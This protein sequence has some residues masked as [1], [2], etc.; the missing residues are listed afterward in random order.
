[1]PPSAATTASDGETRYVQLSPSWITVKTAPGV[2]TPRGKIRISPVRLFVLPL[3]GL[4]FGRALYKTMVPRSDLPI[5]ISIQMY[6]DFAYL[7]QPGDVI[8]VIHP[9]LAVIPP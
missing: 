1:M 4:V 9:E 8:T 7:E 2:E 6:S 3:V 5:M